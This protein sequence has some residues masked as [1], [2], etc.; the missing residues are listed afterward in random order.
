MKLSVVIPAY[1]E[2]DYIGIP[3]N[4]LSQQDYKDFEIIVCLNNCTDNTEK[5]VEGIAKK[6]NLNLKIVKERKKGVSHARYTG[7]NHARGEIIAS[8]DSDTYYPKDWTQKIISSFSQEN[9]ACLYGSVEIKSD[10]RLMRW[11][12]RYLF[13]AFLRISHFFHNYN[14]NG[15]NFA[16]LKKDFKEIGGFNT[17]WQSA[18]DVYIGIK[19]KELKKSVKYDPKLIV[20]T[21]DRRFQEKKASSLLHHVKNY[22]NVFIRKKEPASFKDIR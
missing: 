13:S 19:L 4:S 2:E 9:I 20:F 22:I 12:A 21:H 3:L 6:N 7:F 15:M 18:E 1:N 5:I 8:V 16:V 10:S 17:K 11:S 14:L